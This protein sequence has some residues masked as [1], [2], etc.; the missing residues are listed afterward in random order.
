MPL[1]PLPACMV[2][3]RTRRCCVHPEFPSRHLRRP[4]LRDHQ[5]VVVDCGGYR[6]EDTGSLVTDHELD[7]AQKAEPVGSEAETAFGSSAK[8][9]V[10]ILGK[11][12]QL[13]QAVRKQ[14]FE[15]TLQ[16]FQ[17]SRPFGIPSSEILGP[18]HAFSDR[19]GHRQR[20][21]VKSVSA[22]LS[23]HALWTARPNWVVVTYRPNS[24]RHARNCSIL[25]HHTWSLPHTR[26]EIR[27]QLTTQHAKLG[28]R[29]LKSLVQLIECRIWSDDAQEAFDSVGVSFVR[30]WREFELLLKYFVQASFGS[31]PYLQDRV[32][33]HRYRQRSEIAFVA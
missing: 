10:H 21:K 13:S 28:H 14:K 5:S 9:L 3:S 24:V 20:R 8:V 32:S 26:S 19:A 30:V 17:L 23:A 7:P 15:I 6:G 18:F 2:L 11:G 29:A 12:C 33:Q 16:F 4:V 31:G 22:F 27:S 1:P 25:V